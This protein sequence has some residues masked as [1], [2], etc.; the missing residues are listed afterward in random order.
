MGITYSTYVGPYA[1]CAITLVDE[2]RMILSCLKKGCANHGQPMSGNKYCPLCSNRILS[3]EVPYR[4]P[5]VD[6]WD[7]SE[8][9]Q[10][11]LSSAS[12]DAY[13]NWSESNL[14]H[15][16]LPNVRIPEQRDGHLESRCDFFQTPISVVQVANERSAFEEF[17]AKELAELETAYGSD[18]VTVEWGIIQYYS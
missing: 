4:A 1:R 2:R 12:G 10:E 9:I 13:S 17:F 6:Q 18:A 14:A 15:L 16:W 11:R 8:R 5:S 3:L 7:V